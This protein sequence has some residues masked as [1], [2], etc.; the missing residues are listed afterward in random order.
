M[1]GVTMTGE[2]RGIYMA[3]HEGGHLRWQQGRPA[4]LRLPTDVS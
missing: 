1:R 2:R 4:G 3:N